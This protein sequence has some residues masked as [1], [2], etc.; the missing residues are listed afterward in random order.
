MK[1]SKI[2]ELEI[3]RLV[4]CLYFIFFFSAHLLARSFRYQKGSC[5]SPFNERINEANFPASFPSITCP[6]FLM[7]VNDMNIQV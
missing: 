2:L 4:L 3:F 6:Y 7:T 1:F 5:R